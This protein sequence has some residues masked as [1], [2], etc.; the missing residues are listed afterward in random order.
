VTLGEA[1][2]LLQNFAKGFAESL[3]ALFCS[4]G[5]YLGCEATRMAG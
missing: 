3:V 1:I 2:L 4:S 5:D